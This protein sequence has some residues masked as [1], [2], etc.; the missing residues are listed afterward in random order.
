MT[1]NRNKVAIISTSLAHGGAERSAS[2]LSFIL[3]DLNFEVHN[4]VINDGVD[5]PYAGSLYC[6]EK[7]GL[8]KITFFKKIKK[9]V[10]LY[11]Y[12]KSHNIDCIVDHRPRNNLLRELIANWIY[13]SKKKFSVVHSSH[14][15]IYFPNSVFWAKMVYRNTAKIICVSSA[16]EKQVQQR[17]ALANTRTINNP[18]DFSKIKLER[19]GASKGN[20]VLYFGR[21]DDKVKNFGLMIEAYFLSKIFLKGYLLYLMGEGKDLSRIKDLVRNFK[22]EEYVVVIPFQANPFATV[23]QARFTLLSSRFEGFPMAIVESLALGTPVISVDCNS[24]PREIIKH[25]QNGLLVENNNAHALSVAMKQLIED[26]DLY[27]FCK[28][29]ASKSVEHLSLAAISKQ[30][31]AVLFEKN[32]K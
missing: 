15:D 27:D 8:K 19:K 11:Q 14:L 25:E 31:E 30:W 18:Y 5:Y 6:L 28:F 1:T 23:Q 21:F 13:G 10:A 32:D 29:N 12:L 3:S 9:G 24:G 22:L 26:V 16:I 7:E 20:Y 2:L 17:F 4:I